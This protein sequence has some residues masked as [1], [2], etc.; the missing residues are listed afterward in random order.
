MF[1]GPATLT[2]GSG[3]LA[4]GG[5][6]SEWLGPPPSRKD[7]ALLGVLAFTFTLLRGLLPCPPRLLDTPTQLGIDLKW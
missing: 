2:N 7:H 6:S 3:S 1:P 5:R 4:A